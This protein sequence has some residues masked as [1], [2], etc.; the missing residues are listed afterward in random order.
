[1]KSTISFFLTKL[2]VG[3]CFVYFL[4]FFS[5]YGQNSTYAFFYEAKAIVDTMNLLTPSS[6]YMV[7]W[8]NGQYSVFQSYYGYE[9]DMYVEEAAKKAETSGNL[10]LSAIVANRKS[11]NRELFTY[12][13]HKDKSSQKLTFYE[14]LFSD[15]YQYRQE[16]GKLKWTIL[17]DEKEVLGMRSIKATTTYAGRNYVAWFAED[18]PI[19]DG[20]YIFHGLPGLIVELYDDQQHYHFILKETAEQEVEMNKIVPSKTIQTSRVQYLKTKRKYFANVALGLPP[21][22][23]NNM[24]AQQLKDIQS[25]FDRANNPLELEIE[26]EF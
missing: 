19:N 25:R 26:K 5:A 20:P 8:T 10:D 23:L 6:D 7:L 3:F 16:L 18:I 12:K 14:K 22:A 15:F 4:S 21:Q 24:N 11:R 1:M 17:S 2:I 13:I 9:N